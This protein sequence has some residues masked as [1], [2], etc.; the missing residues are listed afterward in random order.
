MR[1]LWTAASGMATQQTNVDNISNNLANVNTTAFKKSTI[2]FKSLLYQNLQSTSTNNAG[3][4]KPVAAQVGSGSRVA[5]TSSIYSQGTLQPSEDCFAMAISGQG[6]FK[7]QDTDGTIKYTRNGNFSVSIV[8]GGTMLC[9]GD[10]SP[11]L[12][13]NNKKIVIPANCSATTMSVDEAGN[14]YATNDAGKIVDLG[15]KMGIVQ[16]NNPAGL[17][18]LGGTMVKATPASGEPVAE[19]GNASLNPSK[20]RQ[21]Y[22]E[23]SNVDVADEMVNL[24]VAQRAYEMNSKAIKAAD[25]ML[26]QANNLRG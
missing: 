24:I 8:P 17:E 12:D 16:F 1:A 26:Q 6:F 15:I 18:Q 20:V 21:Y 23:A 7:V 13:V 19:N 2:E 14:I 5:S 25:E 9:S 22:T 11:V 4:T 10:G 3:E